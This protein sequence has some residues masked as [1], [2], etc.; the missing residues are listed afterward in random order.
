MV[1]I[2][3]ELADGELTVETELPTGTTGVLDLEGR[4]PEQLGP[5][6]HRRT[7][8]DETVLSGLSGC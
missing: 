3:W 6:R 8:P 5:G 4:A 1:A 2:S 7:V